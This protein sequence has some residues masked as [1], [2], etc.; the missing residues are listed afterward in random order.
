MGIFGIITFLAIIFNAIRY[1]LNAMF[2]SKVHNNKTI[3][4]ALLA[5]IL[6]FLL[7]GLTEYS[8]Y[9][10]KMVF[11]FWLIISLIMSVREIVLKESLT[12][13]EKSPGEIND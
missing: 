8:F 6:G 2:R 11:L 7:H 13:I 10:F 1:G 12:I 5:G 9:N 4:A 3:I